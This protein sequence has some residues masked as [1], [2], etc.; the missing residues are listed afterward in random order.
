MLGFAWLTLRQAQEALKN[1]RLEEAQRLLCEPDTRGHK[2]SWELLQQLAGGFVQRG[3]RHL[4]HDDAPAA[5]NDL[6]LA[7]QVGVSDDA[8]AKLRQAL[9]RR[10]LGEA[11]K[12]LDAGEPS[13]AIEMLAR[14]RDRAVQQADL[15]LLEEAGK[16]WMLAR[17]LAARGEFARALTSLDRVG[18]LLPETPAA[19]RHYR[20]E[21]EQAGAAFSGLLGELHEA[22]NREDWRNVLL[23]S[24]RVLALAPQHAEARKAR[25]L[26]WKTIEPAT[27]PSPRPRS[28]PA[29]SSAP[30]EQPAQRFLLWVDGVGGFLLCLGNRITIGQATAEAFVDVPICA[31]ISRVHA[32]LTRDSEGYL[33]EALRPV[34]V[35]D[36]PAEKALLRPGDSV[37][38]GTCRLQFGQPV[39]VSATARLDLSSGHRLPLALDAVFLM[40][41][42]LVLGAGPQAHIVIPDLVEPV[43]LFRNKDS[44]GVRHSGKLQ[45]DGQPCKDRAVLGAAAKVNGDDFCFAVET[46]GARLGRSHHSV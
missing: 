42:T 14:L 18:Q 28:E 39:P 35:N 20:G 22:L 31:D 10:D 41:D 17:D 6:I 1:G 34:Q 8:A 23:M 12:L 30:A 25:S 27:S 2:A 46:V 4:E 21:V 45:V 11:R 37:T 29:S 7:E 33:L 32:A 3:E 5:W 40:A 15:Q 16:S 13:R 26:A 24:E 38:L 43:M 9:I 44:L 19:L 36:R